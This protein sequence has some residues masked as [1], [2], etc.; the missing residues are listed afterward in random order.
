MLF[1]ARSRGCPSPSGADRTIRFR[2]THHRA[3]RSAS[4]EAR[5]KV[6]REW[7]EKT[8]KSREVLIVTPHAEAGTS[9]VARSTPALG[10][11]FGW[12]T[13]TLGQ[14]ASAL[15]RRALATRGIVAVSAL[16]TQAVCTTVV[17]RLLSVDQLG[18]FT[19]VAH[20]PGLPRALARTFSDLRMGAVDRAALADPDLVRALVAYEE[21]LLRG[22]L[23]D[24]ADVFREATE[25]VARGDANDLLGRPTL[26]LDVR[27]ESTREREL[28]SAILARSEASL[29][30]FAEGDLASERSAAA[31]G[32]SVESIAAQ[33]PLA[34]L[35][36]QLFS[37]EAV[38]ERSE[39]GALTL[40][41]A[42][43]ES[44]ECVEIVRRIRDE[45]RNGVPFDRM[46][47]LLRAPAAYQ[48]HLVEALRRADIEAYFARGT[49]TPDPPGRA[50]LAL[51]A[52]A[53]EGLS[54]ARFAEYLSLGE[55]PKADDEGAP[56]RGRAVLRVPPDDETISLAATR[57]R[58]SSGEDE[59]PE[60]E[61]ESPDKAP[62]V[63]GSLRAPRQWERIIVG[64]AVIGGIERWRGRLKS[65]DVELEQ[66][67]NGV[68]E[69]ELALRERLMRDRAALHNLTQFAMPLLEELA[70]LPASAAWGEWID[71]L[72]K[73]ATMAL[74]RPER[75]LRVLGELSP[76][77][78]VGPVTL[79][80]ARLVLDSRLGVA[81]ER[82][83]GRRQGRV[84]VGS[85]DDARGCSFDVVFVPGLAERVF[86]QK[87]SQDPILMDDAR[88]KTSALLATNAQRAEDE[89]LALRLAVGA[90]TQRVVVS[91]PRLDL[92]QARPRTP[93]FYALDLV[94]ASEGELPSYARIAEQA[95]ALSGARIGW[96]A[97]AD[98][99]QAIDEAEYDLAIL[100][101][102]LRMPEADAVGGARY[103][104]N[105]ND[106]LQRGLR[107]RWMRWDSRKWEAAD[108]LVN[109]SEEA[110]E[111]LAAHS[112]LA[113]SFSPTAL[114]HFASC[115]YRFLLQAVHRLQPMEEPIEIE[116]LNPLQKG[117]LMHETI[118]ETLVALRAAGL[119]PVTAET[120]EQARE[121]LDV[122]AAK[123]AASFRAELKPA[124]ERVW[125]D[126]VAQVKT[127]LAEWL[128]RMFD[129]R[130]E[131]EWVPTYFE[132]SFGLKK[133]QRGQRDPNSREEDVK[134]PVGI[135]LRGS[136]DLV[137][138]HKE[139][140][141]LRATDFKSGKVRAKDE[142]IIGGGKTLQ[143]VLYA[144]A[145]EQ[146]L[147]D[148]PG[149]EGRLYY[150]TSVGGYQS[151]A[152]PLDAIARD[153]AKIIADTVGDALTRGFLPAAPADGECQW[154]DY[155]TVC[156][157]YEQER[158]KA[159][160]GKPA[161]PKLVELRRRS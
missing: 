1:G 7:L 10:A 3:F 65:A 24:R 112:L 35:Q 47:V 59:E 144:L 126:A 105:A 80:Q 33:G 81:T 152:I 6:A 107:A 48:G 19:P 94:R 129:R 49:P 113:R 37:R 142:T 36:R 69:G 158:T 141:K 2:V 70:S 110:Q 38:T 15:S 76:M 98:A 82:P 157:P 72:S 77:K 104:L 71:R 29:V 90:A 159:N 8:G 67:L 16:A 121:I 20:F 97:P 74:R 136:I 101:R 28:C 149:Y 14:L 103:L 123:V 147:A 30:T 31:M 51:V 151:F 21:E 46:A 40:L 146:M 39:P 23:C 132:L 95:N 79:A 87:I 148:A 134:L 153:E 22:S 154:C 18:R 92:D 26:L 119:L 4:A 56:P 139:S 34:H 78:E 53:I 11:T 131:A 106:H 91:Y 75:I 44:R 41:S 109:P 89:R 64:A 86:P 118:Y 63:S 140:G 116:E 85:A 61:D 143:P 96:P 73:L 117:S 9:L 62:V 12:T 68:E 99:R 43:G 150:C 32:M 54:A 135:R 128:K 108:G 93:S 130:D 102:I 52:C 42:P 5:L 114:Q 137:E 25:L 66:Q 50:M 58:D 45:A 127:D 55:L 83:K 133:E 27:I 155:R 111:A 115:P 125:L 88:K 120:H 160:K 13:I 84:F 100:D 60:E 145:I 17:H 138:R 124:I 156:G 122:Q 57:A 161:I